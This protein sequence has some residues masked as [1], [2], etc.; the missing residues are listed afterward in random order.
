MLLTSV[1]RLEAAQKVLSV[2]QDLGGVLNSSKVGPG[3]WL[4]CKIHAEWIYLLT[5]WEGESVCERDFLPGIFV[6]IL[7][8][9]FPIRGAN[10]WLQI[11]KVSQEFKGKGLTG[12]YWLAFCL[13]FGKICYFILWWHLPLQNHK[14]PSLCH[15]LSNFNPLIEA[16]LFVIGEWGV[17]QAS[18]KVF[19]FFT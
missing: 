15:G 17:S 9:S 13:D 7:K 4:L 16:S 5:Y 6:W 10:W 19:Y 12:W 11:F 3:F 18:L 1:L 14:I 2:W 8:L